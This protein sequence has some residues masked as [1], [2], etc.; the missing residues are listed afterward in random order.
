MLMSGPCHQP[1]I[2]VSKRYSRNFRIVLEP[3]APDP[4]KSLLRYSM[5][6][7]VNPA[8][9]EVFLARKNLIN[10]IPGLQA[11][12]WITPMSVW[13]TRRYFLNAGVIFLT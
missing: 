12:G 3:S 8:E 6:G 7:T 2:R 1:E 5:P 11:W 4:G 10:Y 9:A 13:K